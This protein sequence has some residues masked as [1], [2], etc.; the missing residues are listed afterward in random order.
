ML[1]G[2]E[3]AFKPT[4]LLFRERASFEYRLGGK[5]LHALNGTRSHEFMHIYTLFNADFMRIPFEGMK[6]AF[7]KHLMRRMKI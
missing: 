1:H 6:R 5:L 4:S 7:L 3:S 2:V